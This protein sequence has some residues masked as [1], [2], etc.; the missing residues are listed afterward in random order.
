MRVPMDEAD[1]E[2]Q[3][4]TSIRKI[5]NHFDS[6][7]ELHPSLRWRDY[8]CLAHHFLR[9]PDDAA[10]EILLE[11]QLERLHDGRIAS[12][13]SCSECEKTLLERPLHLCRKCYL[14]VLCHTCYKKRA[15]S[16]IASASSEGHTYLEYGGEEWWN[17]PKGSVN[18]A[19]Q[20]IDT[21]LASV[22]AQYMPTLDP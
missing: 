3:V 1:R 11:T 12:E 13:S 19:G 17:L 6:L 7:G 18:A 4:K 21:W 8:L 16:E 14:E 5:F 22:K 20:T 9:V 10:T 15:D 2:L